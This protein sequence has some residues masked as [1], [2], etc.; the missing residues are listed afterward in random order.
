MRKL[1]DS[2]VLAASIVTLFA[3]ASPAPAV[4]PAA[5]AAAR[6]MPNVHWKSDQEVV[7]DFTCLGNAERAVL[8]TTNSEI[9]VA[10]FTDGMNMR[11]K[12]LRFPSGR[13]NPETASLVAEDL[14]FKKKQ[15]EKELGYVPEGLKPS[16][17]CKGLNMSDQNTD[18]AHIYWHREKRRFLSWSL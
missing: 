10:V 18:S 7:G 8:G 13:R 16:K 4:E 1:V 14:D 17:T 15:L 11:P 2:G 12:V 6:L 3:L 9:V 5:V